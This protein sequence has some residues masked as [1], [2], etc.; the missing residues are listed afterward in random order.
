MDEVKEA[1]KKMKNGK[2]LGHDDIPAE[3]WKCL[4]KSS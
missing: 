1:L 4:E 2:T 3:V